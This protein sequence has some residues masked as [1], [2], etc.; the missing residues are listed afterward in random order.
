MKSGGEIKV[1][2]VGKADRALVNQAAAR[3]APAGVDPSP[4]KARN[5]NYT[6]NRGYRGEADWCKYLTDRGVPTKRHFMSG[7][8]E[9]GD[10]TTTPPCMPDNK[11]K[12]QVKRKKEIPAWLELDQHDYTAVREDRGEWYVV[13]RASLFRDLLQ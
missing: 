7:M 8:Y 5:G 4:K 6:R 1:G 9:G 13:I 10:C 2:G 11:L 3:L 12:G